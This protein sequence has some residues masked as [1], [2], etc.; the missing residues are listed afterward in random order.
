MVSRC[1]NMRVPARPQYTARTRPAQARGPPVHTAAPCPRLRRRMEK[2]GLPWYPAGKEGNQM[3]ITLPSPTTIPDLLI[4]LL[5]RTPC[6][7]ALS[8]REAGY[9][10]RLS[11]EEVAREVR[12]VALGL[13]KLG[14]KPGDSVGLLAPSSPHWVITDLA[15]MSIGAVSVPLFPNLSPDHLLY[16]SDNTG[17]QWLVAIGAEQWRL[18]EPHARRCRAVVGEGGPE[19]PR[20]I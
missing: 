17:M 8:W 16:E 12:R 10:R 9:W 2:H 20:A 15:I 4:G 18:V 19:P 11:T 1:V 6:S 5:S 14:V 3:S 7:A 13:I